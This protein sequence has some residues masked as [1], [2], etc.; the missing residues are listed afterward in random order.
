VDFS[1]CSLAGIKY[2]AFL[3]KTLRA[4]LRLF[5]VTYRYPNY[6]IADRVGARLAPLDEAEQ[7]AARQEMEELKQIKFL[8]G[9][10]LQ[11]E[12]RSG[13]AI[14]EICGAAGRPDVDLIVASTHG[15]TGFKHALIGS[16]A[17]HV[18]RYAECRVMVVP[19]RSHKM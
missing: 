5:H 17:E 19:T 7:E 6:V 2:A 11:T 8:R 1:E 3:A 13:H 9:L 12:I 18:V 15:R 16:I 14:D 4:T 10:S